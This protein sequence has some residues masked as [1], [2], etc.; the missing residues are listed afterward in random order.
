[1]KRESEVRK[2]V[3]HMARE[4]LVLKKSIAKI[5]KSMRLLLGSLD[6]SDIAMLDS[7]EQIDFSEF[8]SRL[9]LRAYKSLERAGVVDSISLARLTVARLC[10]VKNCGETTVAEVQDLLAEYGVALPAED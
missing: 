2:R 8:R 10:E 6:M 9:S 7:C 4:V 1:M 3:T 5:E